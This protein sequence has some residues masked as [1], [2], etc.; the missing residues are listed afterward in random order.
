[1]AFIY[2]F[3]YTISIHSCLL[4]YTY[5]LRSFWK[6]SRCANNTLSSWGYY[7]YQFIKTRYL[8]SRTYHKTYL[9]LPVYHQTML[10]LIHH[11]MLF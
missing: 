9:I 5:L 2:S 10:V 7:V 4:T 3:P 11:A 8:V 6:F 1:M